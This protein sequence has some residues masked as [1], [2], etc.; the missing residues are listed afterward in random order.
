M[1][2]IVFMKRF[3]KS[4]NRC[5]LDVELQCLNPN[6]ILEYLI[7]FQRKKKFVVFFGLACFQ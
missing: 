5:T 2:I 4:A 7:G 6:L 1:K 3:L